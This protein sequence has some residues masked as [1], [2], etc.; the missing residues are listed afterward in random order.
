MVKG[1]IFMGETYT[2]AKARLYRIYSGMKQRC[3]NK[4]NPS[5]KR[6]GLLGITICADWL[7]KKGFLNFY[8]WALENGYR[9]DLTIDRINPKMGYSPNN[10]Q[11]LSFSENSKKAWSDTGRKKY[12]E[13]FYAMFN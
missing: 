12:E 2:Q 11:W 3:Y 1:V 10:C 9:G 4:N 5:Y 13:R 7:D 6:Y 8:K